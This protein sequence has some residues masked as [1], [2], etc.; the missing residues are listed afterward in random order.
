MLTEI[1]TIGD[2][3]LIGQVIDT[4]SAWMAQQLNSIGLKVHQITSV[5]DNKEHILKALEEAAL[6]VNVILITGGLGPTK[7]DITKNTLCTYF[8]AGLKFDQ[9]S[10]DIIE[11]I[12]QSRGRMVTDI[13]RKQAE[14]PDN[15]TV[16]HNYLGTAPGMLFERDN[17]IYI[18]MPGVPSEMKGLMGKSVIPFLKDKFR[19]TPLVH[20]AILTQGVGESFLAEKISSWEDNLPLNMKLAYLPAAGMVRLRISASGKDETILR[21]EVDVEL[22]KLLKIIPDYVYG[23]DEEK[24]E[25]IVGK[26]LREQKK[27]IST[28][29][30][31]TGGFIAHRITTIPGSSEYYIGSVIAYSN[32]VK[33]DQ[34]EV[35]MA[36]IENHGA[37]SEAVVRQMANHALRIFKTDV[38]IAC[39]GIAGPA[40][41]T[42]EKPV[43]TVWI[44]IATHDQTFTKKLQLGSHRERIILETAQHALNML[45]KILLNEDDIKY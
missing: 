43:G 32:E 18:S 9:K 41:G 36:T 8:N 38:S 28:A 42:H 29:E 4:N 17:K 22:Q 1:I 11:S 19:L 10:F 21:K 14:V 2:E 40:G 39:S 35:D 44:A 7:D 25:E 27:T 15:C 37:V 6:R 20:K 3:L 23:F 34:L 24:L 13:N 5:S 12:F 33:T 45:R 31:C 26:L 30:S 16:I